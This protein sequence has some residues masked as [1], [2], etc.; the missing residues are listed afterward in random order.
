MASCICQG[1]VGPK[2]WYIEILDPY[3]S[4]ALLYF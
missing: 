4:K 3:T 2:A 1:H